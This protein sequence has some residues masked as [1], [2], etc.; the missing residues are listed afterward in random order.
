MQQPN[1]E[2][3]THPVTHG[4]AHDD[5]LSDEQIEML[6]KQAEVRLRDKATSTQ[7][8]PLPTAAD[9]KLPRL[10][11][12]NLPAPYIQTDGDIARLAP[13]RLLDPRQ[14]E[15]ANRIRKVEDPVAVKKKQAEV[16]SRPLR[17]IAYEENIPIF[18]LEQTREPVLGSPC[19]TESYYS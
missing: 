6:L 1:M 2:V 9:F 7:P 19:N 12:A 18:L 5:E 10:E 14:R 17:P 15:L 3:P 11:A 13:A 4:L 8:L 16:R